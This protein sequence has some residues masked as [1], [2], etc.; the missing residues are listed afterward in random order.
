MAVSVGPSGG[1]SDP[2][3]EVNTTPL[4]DVMLVLL[5]MLIVT[6]PIQMHGVQLENPP[7][8]PP[9]PPPVPPVVVDLGI[10]FGGAVTWNGTP[11]PD[12]ATL[13]NYLRQAAQDPDTEIHIRPDGVAK[14][15][16]VARVLALAQQDQVQKIGFARN[17]RFAQ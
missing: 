13:D 3:V 10:D 7:P 2:M 1:S 11:V 14:W 4:I 5:V 8:N 17:E 15:D 16:Y 6:L 9:P 12:T